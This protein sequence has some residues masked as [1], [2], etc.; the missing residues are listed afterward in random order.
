M[1]TSFCTHALSLAGESYNFIGLL[2]PLDAVGSL[3]SFTSK[4]VEVVP[5]FCVLS[6]SNCFETLSKLAFVPSLFRVTWKVFRTKSRELGQWTRLNCRTNVIFVVLEESFN[7]R[8]SNT[9]VNPIG[10]PKTLQLKIACGS[11][12]TS[13]L[14]SLDWSNESEEFKFNFL[15]IKIIY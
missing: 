11:R 4:L 15:I 10:F 3:G 7:F 2:M 9:P 6:F 12:A 8:S 13:K 5:W 14:I 1:V